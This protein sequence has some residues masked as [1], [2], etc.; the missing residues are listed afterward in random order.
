ML[1]VPFAG[2]VASGATCRPCRRASTENDADKYQLLRATFR[3]TWPQHLSLTKRVS[4]AGLTDVLYPA[5]I[6]GTIISPSWR[7]SHAKI[8]ST[9]VSTFVDS[10]FGDDDNDDDGNVCG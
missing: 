4:S 7:Y 5:Y 2:V 3:V 9:L 1:A 8:W 6:R 10:D